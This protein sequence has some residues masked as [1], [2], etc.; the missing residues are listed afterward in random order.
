MLTHCPVLPIPSADVHV[1]QDVSSL[2][3]AERAREFQS[4]GEWRGE[5]D[6]TEEEV[7]VCAGCGFTFLTHVP[8]QH[9]NCSPSPTIARA[10]GF[11]E[12]SPVWPYFGGNPHPTHM[13]MHMHKYAQIHGMPLHGGHVV[14]VHMP[15]PHPSAL[16]HHATQPQARLVVEARANAVA[17]RDAVDRFL[18]RQRGFSV[19]A[20]P[21][22][23]PSVRAVVVAGAPPLLPPKFDADVNDAWRKRRLV[24]CPPPSH[25]VMCGMLPQ[26]PPQTTKSPWMCGL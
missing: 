2:E 13:H 25:P 18:D 16:P 6:F 4:K 21:H 14:D 26:S 7:S 15:P 1:V 24:R 9:P 12:S 17:A 3:A 5:E 19:A 23:T 8:S 10:L 11:L 22:Q 20:G